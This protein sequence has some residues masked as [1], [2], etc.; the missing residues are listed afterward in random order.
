ML[1]IARKALVCVW[2][3]CLLGHSF[4]R[5]LWLRLQVRTHTAL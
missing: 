1:K 4:L 5:L 3:D 2:L